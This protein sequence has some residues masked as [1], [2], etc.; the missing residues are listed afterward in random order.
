MKTLI[1]EDH[2]DIDNKYFD[3]YGDLGYSETYLRFTYSPEQI[4]RDMV[5]N[6]IDFETILDAGCA[7][8]ELVRD[9]RRLGIKAYGIEN[10]KDILKKS[11]AKNY[12]V[13]M[14]ILDMSDIKDNTFD[15]VYSNAL[16]YFYPQQIPSILKEFKRILKKAFYLCCPFSD[17][18]VHFEDKYRKFLASKKWWEKQFIEA[19]FEKINENL[20]II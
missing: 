13:Y 14:D 12:C 11:V 15:V 2:K 8:G 16:M 4:I 6:D 18:P 20:Y 5:N 1:I 17:N 3:Q 7:S 9:F 19:G 10:N